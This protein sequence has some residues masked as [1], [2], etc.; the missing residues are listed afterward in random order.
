MGNISHNK[1]RWYG[2]AGL[3]FA[4]GDDPDTADDE[5]FRQT[6]LQDNNG[7]LGGVTSFRYY[8]ELS[9]PELSNLFIATVGVGKRL[10]TDLSVDVIAHYYRLHETSSQ[11][12]EVEWDS[13][14]SGGNK[15]LGWETDV[16]VGYRGASK[17]A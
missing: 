16:I 15:S 10:T 11:L 6:G 1:H 2:S 7:K 4:T 9:D 14:L 5:T 8:G 13:D 17:V 3:A 12:E